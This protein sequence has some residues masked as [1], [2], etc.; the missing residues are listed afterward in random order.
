M[1]GS[2]SAHRD[3]IGGPSSWALVAYQSLNSHSPTRCND[4]EET[5]ETGLTLT[6]TSLD[7]SVGRAVSPTNRFSAG[8]APSLM[9]TALIVATI[10]T[11]LQ[12]IR[13]QLL[14]RDEM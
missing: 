3:S 7:D 13:A 5:L 4:V 6:R 12:T 1:S 14:F 9:R 8:P 11:R 2:P 10:V